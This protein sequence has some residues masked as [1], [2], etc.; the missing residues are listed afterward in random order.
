VPYIDRDRLRLV[1]AVCPKIRRG[2]PEDQRAR[3]DAF[4]RGRAG[5]PVPQ[6]VES[7]AG[8]EAALEEGRPDLLFFLCHAT[9]EALEL[10]DDRV[11]PA[12]L[13][14]LLQGAL[15]A[16]YGGL[17][18][19]NACRTAEEG[20]LGSFLGALHEEG[21][22]GVI[23]TEH[24]TIDTF[25]LPFGLDFLEAF[26]DTGEPVGPLLQRL[27]AKGVPLGLLYGAYC[28]PGL[29]VRKKGTTRAVAVAEAPRVAGVSLG[30]AAAVARR[31]RAKPAA[32]PEEP[33]RSLAAYGPE[34]RALFVGRGGDVERFAM[35]LD[36]PRTRLL[37][38]HGES[39]IGKSSFLRAGVIPYLEEECFGYRFPRSP[40]ADPGV[41][42]VRATNDLA[43]RLA[44]ALAAL[45][46]GAAAYETP[47]GERVEVDLSAALAGVLGQ[48]PA[49]LAIRDALRADAAS[50]GR[51]LAAL[52][53]RLPDALVLVIDQAEEIFTLSRRPDEAEGCRL[54]LDLLREASRASGDFKLIVSLRTE[55]YGRLIDG[56]RRGANDVRGVREYLLTG[57]D[58]DGLAEAVVRPTCDEPVPCAR[59][60][61]SEKYRFRY[62]VGLPEVIAHGVLTLRTDRQ[63]SVLPTL[64]VICTQLYERVRDRPE[65][66]RVV[67]FAD[68][69]AIGGVTGGLR[70]NV[71]GLVERLIPGGLESEHDR[72][73]FRAMM[74]GLYLRQ[75][76]GALTTALVP[77]DDLARRWRGQTPFDDLVARASEGRT[78]LLK[79]NT[80]RIGDTGERQYI[81][82]GHD[83]LA[84][85]AA[86]WDDDLQRSARRRRTMATVAGSLAL[87]A[88]MLVMA[89]LAWHNA[90]EARAE[91]REAE[92]RATELAVDRGLSLCEQGDVAGGL[93]W[94]TRG[95]ESAPP[96]ATEL[97]NVIRA[98]LGAWVPLAARLRRVF[99]HR[100]DV[101]SVAI[102]PDGRVVATGSFDRTAR[103][104][105]AETGEPLGPPMPHPSAVQAVA[106]SH[107]G[108][109]LATDCN[110]G[111]VILWNITT[112]QQVGQA[113]P[114]PDLVLSLAFSPD[115][116]VLLTG[117]S[118]KN[119]RLWDLQTREPIGPLLAHSAAIE[120]VCFSPD[121][122]WAVSAGWDKTVRFWD[123]KTGHSTDIPVIRNDSEVRAIAVSVDGKSVL[124][125][126]MDRY[127]R[128]WSVG[129]AKMVRSYGPHGAALYG[130]AFS[131]DGRTILT[132][133]GDGTAR[134]WDLQS[135]R[136]LG[137][138]LRHQGWVASVAFTADGKK[139]LTGSGDRVARLW[140]NPAAFRPGMTLPHDATVY[141]GAFAKGGQTVFTTSEDRSVR[142]WN[143]SDGSPLGPPCSLPEAAWSISL[144]H[145][146]RQMLIVS[147]TKVYTADVAEWPKVH[148]TGLNLGK[149][150]VGV[151]S[152]DGRLFATGGE[153][154]K[155]R[156]WALPS[157]TLRSEIEQNSPIHGLNFSPDGKRLIVGSEDGMARVWDLIARREVRPALPHLGCVYG[158]AIASDEG[159]LLTGSDDMRARLVGVTGQP[160]SRVMLPHQASVFG[161]DFAPD[162]RT[163]ATSAN[164]G[165][166]RVWDVA[167][168]K[169]V[170]PAMRHEAGV[171]NVHFSPDGRTLLTASYDKTARLWSI[172][173]SPVAGDVGLIKTWVE[174]LAGLTLSDENFMESLGVEAWKKRQAAIPHSLIRS[175]P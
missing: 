37:V 154:G 170:G 81:S 15:G 26:L 66:D 4:A 36:D 105:D 165:S 148:D 153:D 75:P 108:R 100:L 132:G 115:D 74:A 59:E 131:P 25:A 17:A 129:D 47:L 91:R 156:V 77:E 5:G 158:V 79:V 12:D 107:D 44:E 120:A 69:E 54:A 97:Q 78:R 92:V 118:D 162:G 111:S 161:V 84:K 94:L 63:D 171:H 53:G 46:S 147:E 21:F 32:L 41:L 42:F 56:L 3:L 137:S 140:D 160:G 116:R 126:G 133:C 112:Q 134:I 172:P 33:Y 19:L 23:A 24:Q 142:A 65:G 175:N 88:T 67:R 83:A 58:A 22:S 169:P 121:G 39:G 136:R 90:R 52:A 38:L 28:P 98:N 40:G 138:L 127:A 151:M 76:D 164:D 102:S 16:R 35:L 87:A 104:W 6:V 163:V 123:A 152:R 143:V 70:R 51:L 103:L 174:G 14:E 124:V 135:G 60:I 113:I 48:P 119:A 31:V 168:G 166:V 110:D 61:P 106:I 96:E 62:E 64:Q 89:V 55:Y 13:A 155:A 157:Y 139:I 73:A 71:E 7:R 125:G 11:S 30:G 149:P 167:T 159:T 95:L 101:R 50:L 141:D 68:L 117:C 86:E 146:G 150:Y 122:K 82:L 8:L 144:D 93:L 43:G 45:A 34:D 109:T 145:A 128:L 80:L 1:L 99:P 114:H 72:R 2:L 57:F 49:P 10:G 9:P 130:V 27:R 29:F 18:F 20:Q 85:V 173:N